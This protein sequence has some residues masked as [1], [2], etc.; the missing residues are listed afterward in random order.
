[1]N[2]AGSLFLGTS[3]NYTGG[4]V[5][6]AGS[7]IITNDAALGPTPVVTLVGAR[8]RLTAMPPFRSSFRRCGRRHRVL[9]NTTFQLGGSITGTGNLTRMTMARWSSP[10]QFRHR[11]HYGKW[12]TLNVTAC[13]PMAPALKSPWPIPLPMPHWQSR[14]TMLANKLRRPVCRRDHQ[15]SFR[16]IRL[17]SGTLK[18]AANYGCLQP[19]GYGHYMNAARNGG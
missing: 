17:D 16:V 15:W 4:T 19:M 11:R 13:S 6:N 7:V 12:R 5:I 10:E 3:N 8:C 2:N 1:M 14:G 9:T 18:T